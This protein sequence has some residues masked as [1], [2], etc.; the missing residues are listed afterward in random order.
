MPQPRDPRL[1]LAARRV[2]RNHIMKMYNTISQC[3]DNVLNRANV[4]KAQNMAP[5]ME[6]WEKER[7][8]S[9]EDFHRIYA[10]ASPQEQDFMRCQMDL[11]PDSQLQ[12]LIYDSTKNKGK[13]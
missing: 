2:A 9:V 3:K 4:E 1:R 6:R 7:E 12:K 11:K 5:V 8:L 10:E 13:V